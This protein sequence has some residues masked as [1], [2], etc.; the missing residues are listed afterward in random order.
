MPG[1][2]STHT[3]TSGA[4]RPGPAPVSLSGAGSASVAPNGRT[5]TFSG[6]PGLVWMASGWVC[7]CVGGGIHFSARLSEAHV[8]Q[9]L[10]V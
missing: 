8:S 9:W 7:V 6:S 4:A 1:P 5:G 3:C 10:L 2:P